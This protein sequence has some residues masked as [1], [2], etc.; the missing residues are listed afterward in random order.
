MAVTPVTSSSPDRSAI[1]SASRSRSPLIACSSAAVIVSPVALPSAFSRAPEGS[2]LEWSP[3]VPEA[4][5]QPPE[6]SSQARMQSPR[7]RVQRAGPHAR[8]PRPL[9]SIAIRCVLGPSGLTACGQRCSVCRDRIG[10]WGGPR[11]DCNSHLLT[12]KP[13]NRLFPGIRKSCS[14][15][16]RPFGNLSEP[17]LRRPPAR[18][19]AWD[20]SRGQG[21]NAFA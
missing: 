12:C 6:H 2:H 20:R 7:G 8:S 10:A 3:P 11:T 4:L 16:G 17:S 21:T 13:E 1:S 18:R 19:M 9:R 5:S 14:D 15:G